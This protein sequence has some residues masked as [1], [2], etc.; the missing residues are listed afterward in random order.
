MEH[1]R[2]FFG[3]RLLA[4]NSLGSPSLLVR[5]GIWRR[6]TYLAMFGA[7]PWRQQSGCGGARA[8]LRKRERHFGQGQPCVAMFTKFTMFDK[9]THE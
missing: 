2:L 6:A 5:L 4:K 8:A 7:R 1:S 3:T 9:F